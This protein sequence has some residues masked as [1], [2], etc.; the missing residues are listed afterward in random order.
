MKTGPGWHQPIYSGYQ[1]LHS[2][3][4]ATPWLN[5][6]CCIQEQRLVLQC[7]LR[8]FGIRECTFTCIVRPLLQKPYVAPYHPHFVHTLCGQTRPSHLQQSP[9]ETRLKDKLL[10]QSL[11]TLLLSV[12]LLRRS[13]LLARETWV[14]AALC[15]AASSE[16]ER[17][18]CDCPPGCDSEC[19]L[20][21]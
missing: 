11:P 1:L 18:S 2:Y 21:W 9:D 12:C 14:S 17:E 4:L 6:L 13:G 16:S 8:S 3:N 19:D 15:K 20:C 10:N 7:S 5:T